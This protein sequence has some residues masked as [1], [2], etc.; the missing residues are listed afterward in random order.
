MLTKC[1]YAQNNA[2]IFYAGLGEGEGG[3]G[4]EETEGERVTDVLNDP[5]YMFSLPTV[6]STQTERLRWRLL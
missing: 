5:Q 3:R 4:R 1:Y 6:M 2:S